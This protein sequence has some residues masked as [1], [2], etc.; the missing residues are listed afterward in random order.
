MNFSPIRLGPNHWV[1]HKPD[2]PIYSKLVEVSSNGKEDMIGT[3][4]FGWVLFVTGLLAAIIFPMYIKYV[5]KHVEQS[6]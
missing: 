2:N 4:V 1:Q 6:Q 3:W 5:E